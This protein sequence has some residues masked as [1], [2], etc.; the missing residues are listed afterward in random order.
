MKRWFCCAGP[1]EREILKASMSK[2]I[3]YSS[4]IEHLFRSKYKAGMREV[5]FERKDIEKAA[6]ILGVLLPKNLGDVVYSYRYRK[7][8]PESILATAD[9]G[10]IWIIRGRG[11]GKCRFVQIPDSPI[12][13]NNH[14]ATTKIPDATPGIVAKYSLNDEQALLA[15]VRYNRLIDIFT[16]V[17]CY[18]LQNH[19]RTSVPTIGQ[20]ETDELYVGVDKKGAHYVFPIQAKGGTDQLSI[21]QIEQDFEVCTQKFSLLICRPVAAQF[22]QDDVIAL[23]EFE[24]NEEGIKICS[25]KHYKLTPPAEVTDADLASYRLRTA[26]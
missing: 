18:S 25:E 17:V 8:F 22:M 12:V 19:L 21:V 13:P 6:G 9:A 14:M 3:A 5:D 20:V 16:G 23:F 7:K 10:H 15:R 1:V 24:K 2:K 11:H 4:I 26:D